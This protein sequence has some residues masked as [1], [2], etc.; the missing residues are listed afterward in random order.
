MKTKVYMRVLTVLTIILCIST[1]ILFYDRPSIL[2]VSS[3]LSVVLPIIVSVNITV[4]TILSISLSLQK[5]KKYGL[6]NSDFNKIRSKIYSQ[7]SFLQ[8]CLISIFLI[9]CMSVSY[10]LCLYIS[11]I[12]AAILLIIYSFIFCYEEIPLL[13]HNKKRIN[14]ILTKYLDYL[15]SKEYDI[16][17][18]ETTKIVNKCLVNMAY[19]ESIKQVYWLFKKD[20]KEYDKRFLIDFLNMVN[21]DAFQMQ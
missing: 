15:Y 6:Y 10:L 1:D 16:K 17:D 21:K 18:Q 19:E 20:D 4:V 7:Y 13:N 8:I 12:G 2:N 14:N 9:F 3:G 11:C 5:E